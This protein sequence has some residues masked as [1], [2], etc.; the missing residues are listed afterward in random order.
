MLIYFFDTSNFFL[1]FFT[2]GLFRFL[3]PLA[4]PCSAHGRIGDGIGLFAGKRTMIT[5]CPGLKVERLLFRSDD[6][7]IQNV[8]LA[9]YEQ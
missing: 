2:I 9:A 4:G 5:F 7:G 6:T 1:T 3:L 8:K